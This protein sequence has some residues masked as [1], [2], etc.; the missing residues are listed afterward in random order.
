MAVILFLWHLCEG[1][2]QQMPE[3]VDCGYLA[4]PLWCMRVAQCRAEA[5]DAESWILGGHDSAL[6]SG[7]HDIDFRFLAE[8]SAVY[9]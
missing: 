3:L 6:E 4:A 2:L 1:A 8:L 9:A 5:D 7:M